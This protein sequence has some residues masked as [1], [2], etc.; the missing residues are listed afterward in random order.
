MPGVSRRRFLT[1][2]ALGFALPAVVPLNLANPN[3]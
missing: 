3:G 1:I 2:P